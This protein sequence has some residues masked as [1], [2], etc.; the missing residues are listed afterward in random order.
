MHRLAEESLAAATGDVAARADLLIAAQMRAWIDHDEGERLAL[1]LASAPSAGLCR[2]LW[3]RLAE[4]WHGAAAGAAL[5]AHV[6]ALPVV[7][8]AGPSKSATR[9]TMP[10]VVDRPSLLAETLR[11]HGALRGNETTVLANALVGADAI[12]PAQLPKWRRHA[13]RLEAGDPAPLSL[14]PTPIVVGASEGAYLRF[15]VGTA[16]AAADADLFRDARIER[17]GAPLA[18]AL[19][20]ALAADGVTCLALPREPSD[21]V[22]AVHAGRSA[23]REVAAQL[24]ASRALRNLRTRFGEPSAVISAHRSAD[25]PL[26]GELRLSL[27]SPFAERDAEGFRCPLFAA[28]ALGDVV[29]MLTDLLAD[30]RVSHLHVVGGVHDDRAA[31]TGHLLLFKPETVPAGHS[32]L[33]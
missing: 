9:L 30:C 29:K 19:E 26:G 8:V 5:R 32:V 4:A 16:L 13:A 23:Q 31:G 6:F 1:V 20:A 22:C 10:G 2:H 18:R 28:D 15:L 7:L 24:F 21:P 33:H 12:D 3:R 14:A 11:T 25:A 27:S 17:F